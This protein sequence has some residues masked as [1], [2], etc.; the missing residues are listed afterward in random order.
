M[1]S[2]F[3]VSDQIEYIKNKN[4]GFNRYNVISFQTHSLN[5]KNFDLLLKELE[6]IPGVMSSGPADHELT[7]NTGRTGGLNWPDKQDRIGF[8]NLE[9]GVD[10]IE[11]MGIEI[12]EGRSFDPS[13][14]TDFDKILFNET[15]IAQMG[16]E[17]PTGKTVQVGG[18]DQQIIWIE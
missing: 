8:L 15:A 1:V 13:L 5:D 17:D 18:R 10:F 16:I 6:T 2:V 7:G 9:V 3:I 11:T 14:Q 4:L 12:A